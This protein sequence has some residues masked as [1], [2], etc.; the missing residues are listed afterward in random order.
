[1]IREAKEKEYEE[2]VKIAENDGFEHP[3]KLN[4][5]WIKKR[6][7]QGDE[8]YVFSE[9]SKIIGFVCFQPDFARGSKLH[10]ISVLREEQGKGVGKKLVE[11]IEELTR[12]LGK[13]KIYLYVHQKNKKA[14][15]FY[16]K[17]DFHFSGIFL[18]K[19][20]EGEH[21]LLMCKNLD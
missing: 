21:A 10:F 14:I 6:V 2:L 3:N 13:N 7:N 20:G 12:N 16:L 19:Y 8:F 9:D 18:D 5:E 15:D 11:K 4:L 1:M 17:N